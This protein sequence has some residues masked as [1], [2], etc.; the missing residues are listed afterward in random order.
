MPENACLFF[1]TREQC[2]PRL[3]PQHGDC[4]GFRSCGAISR[5][6]QQAQSQDKGQKARAVAEGQARSSIRGAAT[7]P[8]PPL[9]L[10]H[11]SQDLSPPAQ[12]L[13]R[14]WLP[15]LV[16]AP[17]QGPLTADALTCVTTARLGA[18]EPQVTRNPT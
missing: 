3:K 9:H 1:Y 6:P 11:P 5:H 13:R 4:R 2:H 7:H 15:R 14:S 18:S 10:I 17:V 16:H 8:A 12:S